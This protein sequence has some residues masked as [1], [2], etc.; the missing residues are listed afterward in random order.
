MILALLAALGVGVGQPPSPAPLAGPLVVFNA[1]SLARPFGEALK[2]FA[3]RHP[4]V[5]P[6]QETSGSVE[7]VRRITELGKVPDVIGVADYGLIARMLVPAHARWYAT[8]A[9]NRMVLAYT[10]GS[11]GADEISAANWWQVL[12]RRG[13]RVGRS[14]PALDP[15]GYRTLL[16]LQMAER[17]YGRPG[18]A[19]TLEGVMSGR[20]M[21][22]KEADLTA[23]LQ[24]GE[25]DYA[26]TYRSVARTSGLRYVELPE[27]IDLSSTDMASRYALA[28]VTIPARGGAAPVVVRGEPIVYALTIPTRAPHPEVAAAFVRFVL[29]P[30][31]RAILEQDGLAV[32]PRAATSG[33]VPPGVLP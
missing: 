13:V 19:A 33:E 5:T 24:A 11:L 4:G 26:W 29:G 28:S 1:G 8:F 31:G 14:D 32:L 9:R 17:F 30:E 25:L 21:R 20:Y 16:V 7:A 18:L 15:S 22:P 3:V 12:Q 23:L 6:R 10:A 27:A 2:A